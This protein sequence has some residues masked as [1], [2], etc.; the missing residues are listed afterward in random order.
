MK[1]LANRIIL[2][3]LFLT[4]TTIAFAQVNTEILRKN[5]EKGFYLT[6]E[7]AL[8]CKSGN[9]DEIKVAFKARLDYINKPWYGFIVGKV[10]YT[11][12]D[13]EVSTNKGFSHL[14][15]GRDVNSLI[16]LEAFCQAEYDEFIS[17]QRRYLVGL[18]PR[19]TLY[20]LDRGDKGGLRL[21]ASFGAMYE[22]E[23]LDPDEM[24]TTDDHP[25]T[26]RLLRSTN[27]LS[28]SYAAAKTFAA[29]W[30]VYYQ[31]AFER[32][33]DYRILSEIDLTIHLTNKLALILAWNYRYDS[34]PPSHLK[35]Y[36]CEIANGIRLTL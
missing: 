36:D 4:I 19:F 6:L 33:S 22:Y 25:I 35:R 21:Y 13:D 10:H 27:Y 18:A 30:V 34:D 29:V 2:L 31:P 24:E 8:N 9:T 1:H 15:T 20:K 12:T 3:L 26:S 23:K 5:L 7:S 14:R 17:L 28:I 32:F 11:D 16:S